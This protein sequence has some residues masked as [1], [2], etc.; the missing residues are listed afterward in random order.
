MLRG[1]YVSSCEDTK[2]QR[3]YSVLLSRSTRDIGVVQEQHEKLA[4][5]CKR[6]GGGNGCV[7]CAPA[8]AVC[9]A[10]CD[11]HQ[12]RARVQRERGYIITAIGKRSSL[13]CDGSATA[14]GCFR[15]GCHGDTLGPLPRGCS[16]EYPPSC[17]FRD[18]LL[19]LLPSLDHL[20]PP[21][22]LLS[23]PPPPPLSLSTFLPPPPLPPLSPFAFF[24]PPYTYVFTRPP[25]HP[26]PPSSSPSP[27]LSPLL[28][29]GWLPF[30]GGNGGWLWPLFFLPPSPTSNRASST[31]RF[32]FVT[33]SLIPVLRCT[34]LYIASF[35]RYCCAITIDNNGPRKRDYRIDE[36]S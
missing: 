33:A 36:I 19:S 28:F 10:S 15:V 14:G 34:A 5:A 29:P 31:T 12:Q 21:F 17:L 25:S 4:P 20:F 23:L 22:R 3:S 24:S 18:S 16:L 9:T 35:S 2:I 30:N 11:L 7:H 1:A 26:R 8:R 6:L 32:Y 27:A 13:R